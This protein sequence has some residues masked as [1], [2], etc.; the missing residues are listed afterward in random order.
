MV[1]LYPLRQSPYSKKQFRLHNQMLY[2]LYSDGYLQETIE[3]FL[4]RNGKILKNE[5]ALKFCQ[6]R[7]SELI[8]LWRMKRL[9]NKKQTK[10]IIRRLDE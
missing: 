2:E 4:L 10:A 6:K 1:N 8:R 9:K 7:K 3:S 5:E